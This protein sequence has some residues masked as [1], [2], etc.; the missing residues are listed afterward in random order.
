MASSST[1]RKKETNDETSRGTESL[2]GS[3]SDPTSSSKS[4]RKLH[5]L[6]LL[7]ETGD[8]YLPAVVDSAGENKVQPHGQLCGGRAYRLRT[9]TLPTRGDRLFM[10]GTECARVLGYPDTYSLFHNNPTLYELLATQ[11]EKDYLVGQEIISSSYDATQ[12]AFVTAKSVYR[13]FDS[14]VIQDGRRVHD[15]YWEAQAIEKGYSMLKEDASPRSRTESLPKQVIGKKSLK[16]RIF[17][18][19]AQRIAQIL[20]EETGVTKWGE[21]AVLREPRD[22]LVAR[23]DG[24]LRNYGADLLNPDSELVEAVKMSN[25]LRDWATYTANHFWAMATTS[26]SGETTSTVLQAGGWPSAVRSALESSKTLSQMT[27]GEELMETLYSRKLPRI[28]GFESTKEFARL[29]DWKPLAFLRWQFGTEDVRLGSV[30]TITGSALYAHAATASTYMRKFWPRTADY[31][32]DCVQDA[33]GE[34]AKRHVEQNERKESPSDVSAGKFCQPGHVPSSPVSGIKGR[35]TYCEPTLRVQSQTIW[36]SQSPQKVKFDIDSVYEPLLPTEDSCWL[37]LFDDAVIARSFPIPERGEEMGLELGLDLMAAICGVRHAVEYENSVVLKGFSTM[38]VPVGKTADRVQWHLARNENADEPISYKTGIAQCKGRVGLDQ[39]DVL[40]LPNTRAIVGWCSSAETSLGNPDYDYANIDYSKA[41][42]ARLEP[43]LEG[44]SFGFQHFGMA[45][46]DFR[47]GRRDIKFHYLR[48]GP[49]RSIVSA[50]E[51]TPVALYD[52]TE[53]RGW[54]V[55]ATAL[56]LHIAQHRHFLEPF[57]ASGGLPM[58]LPMKNTTKET[59][60]ANRQLPLSDD[61]SYA[62]QDLINDIWSMLEF[63]IARAADQRCVPG[64]PLSMHTSRRLGGFEYKAI[65]QQRSPISPKE[66]S[67]GGTA[68]GWLSLVEDIDAL[69][70]FASGFG[71]VIHPRDPDREVICREWRSLPCYKDYLATSV[72]TLLDLYDAAG[73]RLDREFLSPSRLRWHRGTASLFEPCLTPREF[74]C[75]C[76]R[77]Q[78]IVTHSRGQVVGPGMLE[79]EGAV[80]FGATGSAPDDGWRSAKAES[81]QLYSQPNL[82]LHG[83]EELQC[84]EGP[85]CDS[86]V[87]QQEPYPAGCSTCREKVTL[88]VRV[89]SSN[90]RNR[91]KQVFEKADTR[92]YD[93]VLAMPEELLDGGVPTAQLGMRR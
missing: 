46:F 42:A 89:E 93:K 31:L 9:F 43:R 7:N 81:G 44:G 66:C 90:S 68:G 36:P 91:T 70:L 33:M 57:V 80:I 5:T 3:S 78:H 71:N 28:P 30:V 6:G 35:I 83:N 23:M 62:F 58:K 75:S 4:S 60:L 39:L 16:T 21:W 50:A 55:P 2:M 53:R 72:S 11:E 85:S 79:E 54:L 45:K 17:Q 74:Q 37:P 15:D 84:L 59:L 40:S 38:L 1:A 12:I 65:V 29:K 86:G 82:P 24:L 48:E 52:T 56:L 8:E 20:I 69:V 26:L 61:E 22:R 49:F 18:R 64:K 87:D 63:L 41:K 51:R 14:R 88:P 47:L 73:C 34:V 27:D 76:S 92:F 77:L 13:C 67:L 10:T 32:L 25:L 19:H